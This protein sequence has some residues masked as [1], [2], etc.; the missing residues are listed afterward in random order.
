MKLG[1]KTQTSY[2]ISYMWNLLKKEYSELI[3]RTETDSQTLENLCFPK[4]TGWG[5]RDGLRVCEGNVLKLGYDDGCTTILNVIKFIE[6]NNIKYIYLKKK[7]K[8]K[9]SF[10]EENDLSLAKTCVGR[11]PNIYDQYL[12]LYMVIITINSI[13]LIKTEAQRR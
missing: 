13:S 9:N 10:P 2:A 7:R 12:K 4:E 6:L 1:S 8:K 11:Y 3:W 5:W